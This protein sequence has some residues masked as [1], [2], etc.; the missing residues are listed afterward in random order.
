MSNFQFL[1]PEF[2]SLAATA[3]GAEKLVYVYPQAAMMCAR[4]SLET[5]LFWL[6]KHD[7]NLVQP[8]DASLHNLLNERAFKELVPGYVWEKMDLIRLAGNRAVH[9]RGFK[10][11]DAQDAIKIISHL[12]LIYIW[13]ERTYGNPQKNRSKPILFM[14]SLIPDLESKTELYTANKEKLQQEDTQFERDLN[15]QH[16]ALKTREKELFEYSASLEE[17]ESRLAEIDAELAK[18]RAEIEAAKR[19]NNLLEDP[20]DY[21]E[22]ETRKLKIDY[23]LA[24][25]GWTMNQ[26]IQIEVP[27]T[28]MPIS[29]ENRSGNGKVDYVLYDKNGL[30]LAL[31]EAKRT[32]V[33][34]KIGQQQAK[35]YADCLEKA[36]GQR[37]IIFYTNGYQTHIWND[38]QGGPPRKIH[39]FYTQ[40]ELKRLI[41]RRQ[42]HTLLESI[43]INSDIAGRAY[44]IRAIQSVL[45]TFQRKNRAALLIMA[46]GTGKTRTA[47]A[48]VDALMRANFVQKV[49]FLADR[50]SLV[51]QATNAFKAHLPDSSPVNLVE[52]REQNGR[53]YLSTYQTMIG[54]IDEMNSDGTRKYGVGMFD[55]IIIDEAHRSVYQKFGEIFKYFDANLIGLTAT[56]RDEVDRDTYGLFGLEIGVP[57]DYYPLD[58]AIADGYLV[59][60]KAFDVPV[61]FIREGVKYH[62]LSNEEKI[63]WESLDW[64]DEGLIPEEINPSQINKKLFNEDTIDKMLKHL[65]EHGLKVDGGD[66]LGKTIIFA[67]NQNHANFIEERFNHHYPHYDGKFARVITHATK[68]AQSLIE[69]FS[70]KDLPE[71]QIAISVDMLDT[72]I[73]VPEVLNLVFYK[74]VRSKVKFIQ[75]IGRGTRLCPDLFAP[76][77]GKTEFYI[78][79]YCSN[80]EYFNENPEG[81][82]ISI[83]E[84]ISQRLFKAR[85]NILTLLRADD[86]QLDETLKEVKEDF[87]AALHS[88]VKSMN[89]QNF[90][91]RTELEHVEKF[92]NRESW[93]QLDDLDIATLRDNISKLPAELPSDNLEAKLFDMLCYNL[94]L[95]VLENNIKSKENYAAKI[96]NIASLLEDKSNIPSVAKQIHLIYEIQS[97]EYWEAVTLPALEILRKS[98]RGLIRLIEK[99][100]SKIVY[101]VLDDE[102]GEMSEIEIPTIKSGVNLAQYKKR[103]EHFIKANENHIT[104]AKLKQGKALTNLDLE[105]LQ[106]FIFDA[107]EV[108]SQ[109]RFESCFGKERSLPQFIRSLVGLDRQA[110]QKAFSKYLQTENYNE[111]QIR[112]IEMIIN[113][114]TENGALTIDQLY[115]APFKGLHYESIDGFFNNEEA[116]NIIHL[117]NGFNQ[118]EIAA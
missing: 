109:E 115:E 97:A 76:D 37:P 117:I 90:I 84:P 100:T 34:P 88:E 41:E 116:D 99:N 14:P 93:D 104:I 17:R 103:V 40:L 91:V 5:L 8:Y 73:D 39:G 63:H 77:I 12:F 49:L 38:Y 83:T 2:K 51:K 53:V 6:Y 3:Q 113:H 60:A 36:T 80:F 79:D 94:E 68:Y 48:L 72:G 32:M 20:T 67:V 118:L 52:S 45:A 16:L 85:I 43:D 62:E 96:I 108:E 54:L 87:K 1:E 82:P 25:A 4:Q 105:E 56:P 74:A 55:L 23:L 102:I 61:K 21:K 112:F 19:T 101:T 31:V 30:P 107:K 92:Q 35:L 57:T 10:Q 78:F 114:L 71:P 111:R 81:A 106:Q 26:D 95:S 46:T 50:T 64:D 58:A 24:E 13:F 33:D 22:D 70:K 9:G 69:D 65:M 59:P 18:K 86:Y 7:K 47:I 66:R 98:L 29:A 28:G 89:P 11:I 44:Q 110:V 27:V 15:K 42:D 75:M